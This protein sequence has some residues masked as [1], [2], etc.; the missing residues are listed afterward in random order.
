MGRKKKIIVEAESLKAKLQDLEDELIGIEEKR[1]KDL[2][3]INATI[4]EKYSEYFAGVI[5]TIDDVCAI[6]KLLQS[7]KQ[8]K[9]QLL[10]IIVMAYHL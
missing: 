3:S 5:L 1:T 9:I 6:V 7:D 2:E 4:K 10:H 8:V